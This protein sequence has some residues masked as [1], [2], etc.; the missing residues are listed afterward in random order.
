MS[1][2]TFKVGDR[3]RPSGRGH[4][5]AR[6]G[7]YIVQGVTPE[8]L[9]VAPEDEPGRPL[10]YEYQYWHFEKIVPFFEVGKRYRAWTAYAGGRVEET[11]TV[12][13]IDTH[14]ETGE[15]YAHG[16]MRRPHPSGGTRT[17]PSSLTSFDGWEEVGEP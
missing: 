3:V 7:V 4:S 10:T 15:R 12:T 9:W 17:Y 6:G 14:P 2:D 5:L 8:R 1:D 11:V 13:H 16:W